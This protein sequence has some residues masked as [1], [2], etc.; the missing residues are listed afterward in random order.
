M[1]A[2]SSSTLTFYLRGTEDECINLAQFDRSSPDEAGAIAFSPQA[3][4]VAFSTVLATGQP[5]GHGAA[6]GLKFSPRP[7]WLRSLHLGSAF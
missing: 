7:I 2:N 4:E 5:C 1:P 6:N 3:F